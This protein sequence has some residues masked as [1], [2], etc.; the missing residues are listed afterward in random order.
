MGGNTR[1]KAA[2]VGLHVELPKFSASTTRRS[3]L[4]VAP[5]A[6]VTVVT[7]VVLLR[8]AARPICVYG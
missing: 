1:R 2:L 7:G 8:W 6:S 3:A 4:A 5:V